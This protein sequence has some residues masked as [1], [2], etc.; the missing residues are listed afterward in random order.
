MQV[1]FLYPCHRLLKECQVGVER[2]RQREAAVTA[3]LA[4]RQQFT[5]HGDVIER[6]EVYKYLGWMMA[7]DDN[8]TQALRPQL[9]KARATWARVERFF[10]VKIRPQS[11]LQNSTWL[12]SKP[13]FYTAARRG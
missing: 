1:Y 5:I 6:V 13:F 12:S 11:L 3:A 4:L 8:D 2:R 9:W 10:G 7:Q